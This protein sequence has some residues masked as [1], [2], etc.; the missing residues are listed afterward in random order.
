MEIQLAIV[1]VSVVGEDSAHTLQE[2]QLDEFAYFMCLRGG[3]GGPNPFVYN[4]VVV[5]VGLCFQLILIN[6][7]IFV[8][9]VVVVIIVIGSSKCLDVELWVKLNSLGLPS[10]RNGT[11]MLTKWRWGNVVFCFLSGGVLCG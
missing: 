10:L 7:D 9:G 3:S 2:R 11:N 5:R 8:K 4:F 6:C 1:V